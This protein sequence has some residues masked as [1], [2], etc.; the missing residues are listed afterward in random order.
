M[1]L[2][3]HNIALE[4]TARMLQLENMKDVGVLLDIENVQDLKIA[5][6]LGEIDFS[7]KEF[8]V[9]RSPHHGDE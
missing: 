3:F 1:K 7:K 6:T 8:I 5:G 2:L 4:K 9:P